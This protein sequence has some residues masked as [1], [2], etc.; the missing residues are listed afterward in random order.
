MTRIL[1]WTPADVAHWLEYDKNLPLVA[2]R[3]IELNVDGAT[4]LEFNDAAWVECGVPTAVERCRLVSEIRHKKISSLQEL[5]SK[6]PVVK[7]SRD[8]ANANEKPVDYRTQLKHAYN[9]TSD[10]GGASEHFPQ[11]HQAVANANRSGAVV[12]SHILGFLGMYNVLALLVFTVAFTCLWE[13]SNKSGLQQVTVTLNNNQS[14]SLYQTSE[15]PGAGSSSS[16]GVGGVGVSKIHGTVLEILDGTIFFLFFASAVYSFFGLNATT[17]GYNAASAC[18]DANA[19]AFFKMPSTA[20]H[21]KSANDFCL[22]G[23]F[24]LLLATLLLA[25]KH[26]V[27]LPWDG[28]SYVTYY[29]A[30]ITIIFLIKSIYGAITSGGDPITM[31]TVVLMGGLMSE[32]PVYPPG[33]SSDW[34]LKSDGKDVEKYLFR[35]VLQRICEKDDNHDEGSSSDSGSGSDSAGVRKKWRR[36]SRKKVSSRVQS[37]LEYYRHVA[38]VEPHT[39]GTHGVNEKTFFQ[40]KRSLPFS[41]TKGRKVTP[42]EFY[43]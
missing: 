16:G 9:F 1:D 34:A 40:E 36:L 12:K 32:K 18:S 21:L 22:F 10:T 43:D 4:L 6:L 2:E 3:I 39:E 30:S 8:P 35:Q 15:N 28:S 25:V 14:A 7:K 27:M 33:A 42:H 31:T 29:V 24:P 13:M 26:I 11:W 41:P 20:A 5:R 19:T 17:I 23:K 37:M 38:L